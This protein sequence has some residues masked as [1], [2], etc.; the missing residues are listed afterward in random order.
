ML[1]LEIAG[2]IAR[3]LILYQK[4]IISKILDFK[5]GNDKKQEL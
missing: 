1:T 3:V 5:F 2:N 4:T